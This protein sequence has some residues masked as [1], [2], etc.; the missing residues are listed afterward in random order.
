MTQPPVSN[1][2]QSV[3]APEQPALPGPELAQGIQI[4]APIASNADFCQFLSDL[5]AEGITDDMI[6]TP[7]EEAVVDAMWEACTFLRD[8][9]PALKGMATGLLR[10]ILNRAA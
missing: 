1:L 8:T 4:P 10:E 9:V 6:R 5:D 2:R 7:V 3:E